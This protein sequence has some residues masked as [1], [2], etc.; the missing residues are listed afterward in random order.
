MAHDREHIELLGTW[1]GEEQIHPTPWTAAGVAQGTV[2]ITEAPRGGVVVDYTET[3]DGSTIVTGHGVVVGDG[4]WWFD[5]YG[6]VPMQPGTASWDDG[7]LTLERRSDRGRTIVRFWRQDV[8][9]HQEIT[10]A[11]PADA[12]L[13]RMLVG[14][15]ERR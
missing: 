14:Q 10:T 9:L 4:W 15:Y 13:V 1:A 2:V 7:I 3:R 12:E 11:S 5:S 8:V 6:F